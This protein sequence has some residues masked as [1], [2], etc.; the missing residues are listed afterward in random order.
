[1]P[2]RCPGS[3]DGGGGGKVKGWSHQESA[4]DLMNR[5]LAEEEGE[6]G[7]EE[8]PSME[9]RGGHEAPPLRAAPREEKGREGSQLTPALASE[10]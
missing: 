1:M 6:E 10:G 9:G 5:E 3:V 2:L 8:V 4:L 7:R